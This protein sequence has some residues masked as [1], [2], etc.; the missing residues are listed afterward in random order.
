[1]RIFCPAIAVLRS[2]RSGGSGCVGPDEPVGPHGPGRRGAPGG[3]GGAGGG[4]GRREWPPPVY[5]TYLTILVTRPAPTVRPP[6]RMANRRPSSTA[7]RSGFAAG[8]PVVS[9]AL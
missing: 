3:A 9:A 2:C 7:L 6:S 8:T 4:G 1:M 5:G